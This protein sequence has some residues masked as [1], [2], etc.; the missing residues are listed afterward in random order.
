MAYFLKSGNTYRV[1]KKE[2]LDITEHLPAGNYI[3]QKDEM[4]GQLYLEQIDGFQA[5]NKVYGDCLKNTDR[6]VSTFMS[7]PSTTGVMLTGEKGSGKTL[8]TKNVCMKLATMD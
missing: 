2:S 4:T 8:L 1:T 7:R 6:I 5:I 3:I